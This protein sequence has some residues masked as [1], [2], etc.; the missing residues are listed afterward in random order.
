[1]AIRF[2]DC[3]RVPACAGVAGFTAALLF[4]AMTPAAA[5]AAPLPPAERCEVGKLK[6]VATYASC[7]LKEEA[8]ALS[9]ATSPDFSRCVDV[10]TT[11]FPKLEEAAGPM[12]CPSEDDVGDIQARSDDY[13]DAVAT[14]LAG[15]TLSTGACGD[16]TIDAGE[17]CEAG[18]LA[19]QTCVTQGFDSGTLACAP[20]C[21]FD[22][23][24]CNS[25]RFED[26]GST[27][28]DH[29]TGL[30]WE[31]K[32]SSDAAANTANAHDADNTYTWTASSNG[33]TMNGT[34]FTDFLLKLNGTVDSGTLV[35]GGCFANHCDWRLPTVD[36]LRSIAILSP[37]CSA[38]PCIQNALLA[39]AASARHWTIS[40]RSPATGAYFVDFS[41]GTTAG[42]FKTTAYAARAVRSIR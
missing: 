19:G 29:L 21:T 11:K 39:P 38:G 23:S 16:A 31:K 15:G 41:N 18:D 12:V 25:T 4:L 40:N 8:T 28:I 7:R 20:G 33:T 35:T 14:L 37:S 24:G 22:T 17:D 26:N 30:E 32:D 36:E 2:P 6:L 13:T 9:K 5:P 10:L 27:V 42:Q 3:V 34:L 1:M